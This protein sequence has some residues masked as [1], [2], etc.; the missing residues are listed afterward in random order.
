MPG[1][2]WLTAAGPV[3]AGETLQIKGIAYF[4]GNGTD[5]NG[6]PFKYWL[7]DSAKA[8]SSFA[9]ACRRRRYFRPAVGVMTCF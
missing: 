3:R 6:N 2:R 4:D 8:V 1:R 9:E 5:S 7:T